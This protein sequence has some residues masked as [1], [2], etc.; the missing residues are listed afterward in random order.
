MDLSADAVLAFPR[1]V[2]FAAYRDELTALVDYLPNVRKIEVLSR[3]EQGGV[4][5][6]HNVWHGGGDIPAAA[7]A[8]LSEAMLSWDDYARWDEARWSC[9][10]R[11]KTRSF[12]EAV[13]CEGEN[14]FVAL[15]DGGTRLEIRGSLSID[16]SKVSGVP[17]FLAGKVAATVEAFLAE[18]IRPNLVET[19]SSLRKHLESKKR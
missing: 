5:E 1:P 6:L 9:G 3:V 10:W 4:I 14:R 7:R 19:A 15:E 13:R 8:F 16:G 2:V 18:K 17:R 11:I 12:T